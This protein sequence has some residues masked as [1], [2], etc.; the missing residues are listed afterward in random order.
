MSDR[1][2][3]CLGGGLRGGGVGPG[4]P[5]PYMRGGCR[6]G[7]DLGRWLG[8]GVGIFI[9]VGREEI[10]VVAVD[11]SADGFA[12]AVAAEGVDVFVLGEVDGLQLGLEHVG[13][14]AGESGFYVATNDGGDE[15]GESGAEIA[16]GEVVVGEEVG[17]I[18]G[19]FFSGLGAG[20]LLGVIE[21]EVRMAGGARGA[22]TAAIGEAKQTQGHAVL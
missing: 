13:D 10:I 4:K 14:G 12:P 7:R 17:E 15:A 19:E 16:G 3:G 20:L 5:G 9:G 11:G 1:W 6:L 21:A 2:S 8:V 18:F 22:A